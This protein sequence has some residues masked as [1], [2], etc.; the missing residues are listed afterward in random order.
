MSIPPVVF[1]DLINLTFLQQILQPADNNDARTRSCMNEN[2]G[3]KYKQ[4]STIYQHGGILHNAGKA[5]EGEAPVEAEGREEEPG[6]AEGG[7]DGVG[8]QEREE[9]ENGDGE[10]DGS[11][12]DSDADPEYHVGKCEVSRCKE[13]VFTAC[14]NCDIFLC[15]DHT[16]EEITS[17]KEHGKI[18]RKMQRDNKRKKTADHIPM[19]E[20]SEPGEAGDNKRNK[21]AHQAPMPE[22][23][24]SPN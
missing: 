19:P 23:K 18:L 3:H 20:I 21:I 22:I 5:G 1:Q 8:G 13:E 7:K 16:N 6:D 9:S 4:V 2:K 12:Y 17:C 24:E 15:F 11:C 10:E 14:E